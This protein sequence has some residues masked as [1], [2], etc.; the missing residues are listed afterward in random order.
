MTDADWTRELR[1]VALHEYAHLHVALHFGIWGW[2]SLRATAGNAF[3]G[4]F[5]AEPSDD[6]DAKRIV[7][8]AGACAEQLDCDPAI[9]PARVMEAIR[10]SPADAAIA[11]TFDAVHV[12]ACLAILRS[13]WPAIVRDA[14]GAIELETREAERATAPSRPPATVSSAA[15]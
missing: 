10:L 7:G 2:V 6:A 14:H 5:T 4:Q 8:L 13:E 15:R 3:A 9:T 1:C 12:A 11:G